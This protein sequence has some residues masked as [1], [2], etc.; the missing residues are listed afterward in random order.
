MYTGIVP[1]WTLG[2]QEHRN[3]LNFSDQILMFLVLFTILFGRVLFPCRIS[4]GFCLDSYV[5]F[6]ALLILTEASMLFQLFLLVLVM[7]LWNYLSKINAAAMVSSLVLR[8]VATLVLL[9]C[10]VTHDFYI[11][12]YIYI[13]YF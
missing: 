11:H 9:G 2:P 5:G 12:I 13:M 1:Q 10:R 3:R 6:L 4:F 8:Y 7:L